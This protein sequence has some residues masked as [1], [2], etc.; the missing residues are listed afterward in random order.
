MSRSDRGVCENSLIFSGIAFVFMN[1]SAPVRGISPFRGDKCLRGQLA[2]SG[3]FHQTASLH[4]KTE[5]KKFLKLT[6][7]PERGGGGAA[8]GGVQ[9][10]RADLVDL[11]LCRLG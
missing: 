7:L 10:A 1:P 3:K 11:P 8:D 9:T 6:T 4:K 2:S 5:I